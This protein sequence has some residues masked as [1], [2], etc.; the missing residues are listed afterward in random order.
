MD[1]SSASVSSGVAFYCRVPGGSSEPGTSTG[2][3]IASSM[4][5]IPP[6]FNDSSH[7]DAFSGSYRAKYRWASE[8]LPPVPPPTPQ[9]AARTAPQE[10]ADVESGDQRVLAT[11][12]PRD[13]QLN[14]RVVS[15][16]ALGCLTFVLVVLALCS[17]VWLL[18][19]GA[20]ANQADVANLELDGVRK[21]AA[22]PAVVLHLEDNS[23][24]VPSQVIKPIGG[25]AVVMTRTRRTMKVRRGKT[26]TPAAWEEESTGDETE[27][28]ELPSAR[29]DARET[30]GP[31]NDDDV[32]Y[33]PSQDTEPTTG[34]ASVEDLF[35]SE[36]VATV[37]LDSLTTRAKHSHSR[38]GSRRSKR[39]HPYPRRHVRGSSI[40][41]SVAIVTFTLSFH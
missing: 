26:T 31:P 22:E 24:S 4:P 25:Q 23:G 32:D 41:D 9:P 5:T 37:T 13:A 21:E 2:F 35:V 19:S 3:Y 14:Q 12:L 18:A 38:K 30:E 16:K 6:T 1:R 8:S 15:D 10:D 28:D 7:R 33:R 29:S 20:L 27:E 11:A 40:T 36:A 17:L 34:S 39:W